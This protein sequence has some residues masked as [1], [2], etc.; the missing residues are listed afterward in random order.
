MHAPADLSAFSGWDIFHW[1]PAWYPSVYD[2]QVNDAARP[3]M[4]TNSLPI[5]VG[6]TP[7]RK[8][9]VYPAKLVSFSIYWHVDGPDKI[10]YA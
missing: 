8:K 4:N 2:N 3:D 5:D 6:F 7:L 10:W 9:G 1:L